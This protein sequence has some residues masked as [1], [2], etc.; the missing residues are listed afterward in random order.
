MTQRS[1]LS[2]DPAAVKP[3]LIRE[4]NAVG[5][6]L[7][8]GSFAKLQDGKPQFWKLGKQAEAVRDENSKCI[9]LKV[10]YN[11]GRASQLFAV[12]GGQKVVL[13]FKAKLAE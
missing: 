10:V 4:V 8:N 12:K 11:S 1:R 7:K 3:V 6:A 9:C 2:R 5:A 13:T